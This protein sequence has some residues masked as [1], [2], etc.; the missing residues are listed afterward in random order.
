VTVP[1]L[2]HVGVGLFFGPDTHML[3]LGRLVQPQLR[4]LLDMGTTTHKCSY[5][6][7]WLRPSHPDTYHDRDCGDL[8][9]AGSSHAARNIPSGDSYLPPPEPADDPDLALFLSSTHLLRPACNTTDLCGAALHPAPMVPTTR[10]APLLEVVDV[11]VAPSAHV[12]SLPRV[13]ASGRR[14]T[15]LRPSVDAALFHPGLHACCRDSGTSIMMS[16]ERT[17]GESQ[18][19]SVDG[20][21]SR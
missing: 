11:L 13:L 4:T 5:V 16:S 20:Q 9:P 15:Y 14:S 8:G 2:L 18:R 3:I 12:A 21:H 6:S 17:N 10:N 19:V 7:S 1:V